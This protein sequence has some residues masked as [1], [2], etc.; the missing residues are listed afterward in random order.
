MSGSP[1]HSFRVSTTSGHPLNLGRRTRPK[2]SLFWGG[3]A[4]QAIASR[5]EDDAVENAEAVAR[6]R[7]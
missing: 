1:T 3:L 2:W 7:L 6:D 4:V 5:G